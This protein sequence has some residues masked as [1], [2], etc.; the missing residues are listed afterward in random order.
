MATR[1]LDES[2]LRLGAGFL[3]L[4]DKEPTLN[5]PFRTPDGPKKFSV[6]VKNKKGNTVKVNFG[7]PSM[8]IKRDDPERR[9]NFRAR[10]H[11]DDPGPKDKAR[12]WSCKFWSTPSVSKLLSQSIDE[13]GMPITEQQDIALGEKDFLDMLDA[14]YLDRMS[15][16]AGDKS[17]PSDFPLAA[18]LAGLDA[19]FEHTK[20]VVLALE[21]VVDHLVEN[22]SDYYTKLKEIEKK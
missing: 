20:D 14:I 2:V 8:E 10:H 9:K 5:K 1:D 18:I 6:Y 12:Y 7:D 22:G 21:I 3:L 19:E 4:E 17:K 15:G 11:C 13:F 16:G